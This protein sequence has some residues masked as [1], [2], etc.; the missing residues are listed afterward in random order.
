MS[1]NQA[2]AGGQSRDGDADRLALR[3]DCGRCVGLCCTLY[4][5]AASA[6]FAFTK[7]ARTP[8]QHQ[9][10]D[11]RCGIH[12]RLR[13]LG[14]A[15]CTAYD[16]MGAGQRIAQEKFPG[17]D[18]RSP[19]V[20]DRM[21][22]AFTVLEELHELLWYL[23]DA[24]GAVGDEA[25]RHA[26][27]ELTD[28][29]E[30]LAGQAGADI[31]RLALA[32]HRQTVEQTL[33]LVSARARRQWAGP[34]PDHHGADLAGARLAGADLRGADL[35]RAILVRADLRGADLRGADL[36]GADLRGAE[37]SGATMAGCLYC[38]T[39]QVRGARGDSSTVLPA[40]VERPTHWAS[41]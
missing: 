9:L 20:A 12:D 38:T 8:C 2:A 10:A 16:C 27:A 5:F 37:L 41:G 40:A 30:E 35:S 25:T 7:P 24:A 18:W 13:P 23:A 34:R 32:S 31:A 17:Q 26:V 22:A 19:E 6:E 28:A 1:G 39:M 33:R 29:T 4:G 15:G 21:F 14:L 36:L 3:A 11:F